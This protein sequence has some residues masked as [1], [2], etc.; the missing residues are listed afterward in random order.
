MM[1]SEVLVETGQFDHGAGP[2]SVDHGR[3]GVDHDR[4]DAVGCS[5]TCSA[6]TTWS[7]TTTTTKATSIST[8]STIPAAPP[9]RRARARAAWA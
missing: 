5:T 9:A 3:H 4:Q 7:A 8:S 1:D 2:P 6:R